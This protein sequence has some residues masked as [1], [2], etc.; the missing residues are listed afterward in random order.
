MSRVEAMHKHFPPARRLTVLLVSKMST[1][2]P[3]LHVLSHALLL[4]VHLAALPQPGIRDQAARRRAGRA[5]GAVDGGHSD[6]S[7][8]TLVSGTRV[9]G[10]SWLKKKFV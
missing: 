7:V 6:Q 1:N 4:M 8:P 5:G 2:Q 3:A 10:C 9:G